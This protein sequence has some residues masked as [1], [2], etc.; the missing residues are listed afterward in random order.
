MQACYLQASA[1]APGNYPGA[2]NSFCWALP[3]TPRA[4]PVQVPTCPATKETAGVHIPGCLVQLCLLIPFVLMLP[5]PFTL[6]QQSGA[7]S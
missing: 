1:F 3:V 5:L 6:K 4:P 7:R 2:T